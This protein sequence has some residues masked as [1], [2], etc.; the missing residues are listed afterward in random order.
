LAESFSGAQK[1]NPAFTDDDK[2][3][4]VFVTCTTPSGHEGFIA[5]E[6]KYSESMSEL[7][8]TMRP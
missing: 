3:F 6:V 1:E 2:A 8:A 4:D 5:I 7:P